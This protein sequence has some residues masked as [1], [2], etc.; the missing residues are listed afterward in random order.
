[1]S[2][3]SL[4]CK[5]CAKL[6][7][8]TPIASQSDRLEFIWPVKPNFPEGGQTVECPHCQS[9]ALY[10]RHQLIVQAGA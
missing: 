3:W 2:Y 4:R 7:P 9:S 5:N 1:M 8:H 10:Q 6:F